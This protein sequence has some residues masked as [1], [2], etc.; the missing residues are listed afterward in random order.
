MKR[1]NIMLGSSA[2]AI[3]FAAG[4]EAETAEDAI[5]V[6]KAAAS[7]RKVKDMYANCGP[8][9]NFLDVARALKVY[10]QAHAVEV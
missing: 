5:R 3:L 7:D 2:N 6:A 4:V 10:D 1:Y 9:E 8:Y